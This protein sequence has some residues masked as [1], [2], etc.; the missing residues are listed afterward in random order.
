[1]KLLPLNLAHGMT[2]RVTPHFR[3]GD[4]KGVPLQV[5][6]CR[7]ELANYNTEKLE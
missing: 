4:I 7:V 2:R 5:D 1:M 6:S 3:V